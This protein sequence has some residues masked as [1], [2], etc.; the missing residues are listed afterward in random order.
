MGESDC[1]CS[2]LLDGRSPFSYD[3]NCADIYGRSLTILL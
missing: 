1:N 3:H 2:M